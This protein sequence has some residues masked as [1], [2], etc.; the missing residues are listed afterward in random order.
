MVQLSATKCSC[1]AILWVSVVSLAAINLCIASQR[2]FIVVS[3]YFVIDSVRKLLDTSSYVMRLGGAWIASH[4]MTG[5]RTSGVEH[6]VSATTRYSYFLTAIIK[7]P[8]WR[9]DE[10][11]S[12]EKTYGLRRCV[13]EGDDWVDKEINHNSNSNKHS[14]R[15]NTSPCGDRGKE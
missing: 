7:I 10:L 2:M 5:F 9:N 12:Q 4:P 6:S 13:S 14:L 11:L 1:I 3:V 15:S 8:T